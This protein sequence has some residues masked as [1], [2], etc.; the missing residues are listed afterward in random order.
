[1]PNTSSTS[2]NA[3]RTSPDRVCQA[4]ASAYLVELI[5]ARRATLTWDTAHRLQ[6]HVHLDSCE[7]VV[8]APRDAAHEPVLLTAPNWDAVRRCPGDQRRHLIESCAISDA[9]GLASVIDMNPVA[10]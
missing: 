7:L 6:G 9:A 1:M 2:V 3:H 4:R 10:A 8:I 5:G